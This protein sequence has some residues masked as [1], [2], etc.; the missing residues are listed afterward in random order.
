MLFWFI[1]LEKIQGTR[2]VSTSHSKTLIFSSLSISS[3]WKINV[4]IC[5]SLLYRWTANMQPWCA[6]NWAFLTC[7]FHVEIL[8]L[9]WGRI[10]FWEF[11]CMHTKNVIIYIP[12]L[13]LTTPI[14]HNIHLPI[15]RFTLNISK[16][17][18]NKILKIDFKIKL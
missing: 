9:L 10:F 13:S 2:E 1:M 7:M 16:I 4:L 5:H 8:S 14:A 11:F 3:L 6:Q 15:M 18:T 17:K 12:F